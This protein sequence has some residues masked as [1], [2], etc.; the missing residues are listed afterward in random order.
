MNF[1]SQATTITTDSGE[2]DSVALSETVTM[3][4]R[5]IEI[6]QN[7]DER[8]QRELLQYQ[9]ILRNLKQECSQIK[10]AIEETHNFESSS[11][12]NRTILD[13][14][15]ASLKDK[16]TDMRHVSYD[17]TLIWKITGVREKMRTYSD[18]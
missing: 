17:G 3:L 10:L 11:N 1:D 14:D 6:L 12:L 7:D 16:L 2:Q 5:G 15:L 4:T 13:Q 18:T 9:L 8:F